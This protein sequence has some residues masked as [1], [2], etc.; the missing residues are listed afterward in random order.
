MKKLFL[1]VVALML[2]LA[3]LKA[4]LHLT[5]NEAFELA[6]Q[7]DAGLE[8]ARMDI[9]EG[10]LAV[11]EAT[12]G[13]LPDLTLTGSTSRFVVAP[14]SVIPFMGNQR[15]RFTPVNDASMS[16]SLSQPLWLGGK[17]GLALDA[18]EA[19]RDLTR[20]SYLTSSAK[21]KKQVVQEY[22][23]LALAEEIVQVA[24]ATW[25]LALKHAER[26]GQLFVV[27]MISEF[28]LLRAQTEAKTLEPEVMR[29]R[30]GRDLALTVLR[31]RLGIDPTTEVLLVDSL[32]GGDGSSHPQEFEQ[33]L[34]QAR[35]QRSEF[36]ALDLQ[37]NLRQI[38]LK[39]EERSIYWPNVF[40]NMSYQV[41]AQDDHYYNMEPSKWISAVRWGIVA[42]VPLFDGWAAKARVEKARLGLNRLELT[43][44]TVLEGL[45][46]EVTTALSEWDRA[47]R[48]VS[49]QREALALAL[50]A[51]KIAEIR[52]EEGAGTEMEIQDA[53][54]AWSRAKL[55]W[56]QGQYDLRVA[57]A[58]YRRV[59]END[60]NLKTE[61]R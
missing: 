56:L 24:Q 5:L 39:I 13:A 54:L 52:F 25:D 11:D 3:S 15:V 26:S 58:E 32:G 37:T 6:E 1:L 34:S 44:R 53:R 14:S 22:Y 42:S 4:Q 61:A 33:A 51:F 23:R 43:K 18:A 29:A 19:Y 47:S 2:P 10:D 57:E 45:R 41:Q 38:G 27:G 40:F 16:L 21:L 7:H 30:M 36:Q 55:G 31:N 12:S 48:Q 59:V 60:H 8:S 17:L 49:I 28:D 46:L 35:S 50:R 20:V 9:H